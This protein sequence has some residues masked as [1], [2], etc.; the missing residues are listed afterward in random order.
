M[1]RRKKMHERVGI[2]PEWARL[3]LLEMSHPHGPRE[4]GDD[5]GDIVARNLVTLG[6]RASRRWNGRDGHRCRTCPI[7]VYLER[8]GAL[9][10]RVNTMAFSGAASV[11]VG[12]ASVTF[13]IPNA[14]VNFIQQADDGCWPECEAEVPAP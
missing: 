11:R 2:S 1:S 10:P 5:D 9:D 6:I 12:D 8:H 14:V 7:A 4:D 13:T 3:L